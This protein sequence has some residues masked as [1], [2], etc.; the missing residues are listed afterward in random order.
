[1]SGKIPRL[2]GGRY[3]QAYPEVLDSPESKAL[4]KVAQLLLFRLTVKCD[5]HSRNGRIAYSVR[6]AA[7]ECRVREKTASAAFDELQDA[8]FID[9]AMVY[10]RNERKAREWR[11]TFFPSPN[12]KQPTDD[13]KGWHTNNFEA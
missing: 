13:W 2:R 4:S 3:V 8:G 7:E 11:L 12:G 1:M 9:L 10:P 5:P 6:Q